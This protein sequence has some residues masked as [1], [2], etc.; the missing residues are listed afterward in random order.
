M[1]DYVDAI[2]NIDIIKPINCRQ[3]GEN[4]LLDKIAPR[5]EKY[6]QDVLDVYT[7]KG[8]YADGNNIHAMKRFYPNIN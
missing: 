2:K 1:G 7:G 8:W 4:F 3:W 6:F 5:Y